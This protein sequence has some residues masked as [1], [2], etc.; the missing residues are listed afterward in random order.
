MSFDNNLE[1]FNECQRMW[2]AFWNPSVGSFTT[3]VACHESRSGKFSCYAQAVALHAIADSASVYKDMTMPIVDQA[4]KSTLKYRN[5]KH[6]AYSVEFHGGTNSGD[7]DINYDDNAH[8]LRALIE[9]YEATGNKNHLSMAKEVMNFMYTGIVEHSYWHIKGLLWHISKNYMSTISNSVGAVAAMRM[10]PHADSKE[11]EQKLYEFAKLCINFI[12]TKMRDPNDD[13]IM[14][15]VNKDSEII[16]IPK[17]SYNQGSTLSA[18]CLLYQY[19]HN[20]EWKEMATKL[21]DGCVNPG[22]TLFDRDYKGDEKRFLHGVSYF[23]QLLIEGVVD[24]IL[25]FKDEGPNDVIE[26]CKFQLVR[27][28]SYFRKYCYDP[29]DGLYFI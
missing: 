5:P 13:V 18:V 15:G 20:P 14:D 9:L 25:T 4:I 12:W 17:Y 10:I 28:L 16:Q 3:Q 19:D 8:L 24:Y 2:Y 29:K 21:V 1:G 26:K 27:H 11:E 6:G 7:E 22:K 23:N